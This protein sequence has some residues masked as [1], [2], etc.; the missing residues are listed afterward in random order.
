MLSDDSCCHLIKPTCLLGAAPL[1]AGTSLCNF[2]TITATIEHS[3][4][5]SHTAE[6]LL[7][8]G[9]PAQLRGGSSDG[10]NACGPVSDAQEAA[11]S[12]LEWP[13]LGGVTVLGWHLPVGDAAVELV[14]RS[15]AC[16]LATSERLALLASA[17]AARPE[18][19][20]IDLSSLNHQ[21]KCGVGVRVRWSSGAAA[22]NG[23][24]AAASA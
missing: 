11:E 15:N 7:Q 13:A 6:V 21:L 5:G 12:K 8:F 20:H 22:S 9:S 3:A 2:L 24:G 16:S 1:Q 14:Q 10:T 23:G 18:G 4:E 17:A 19:L